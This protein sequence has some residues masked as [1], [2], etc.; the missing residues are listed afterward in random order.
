VGDERLAAPGSARDLEIDRRQIDFARTLHGSK[1]DRKILNRESGG[2]ENRD[3]GVRLTA[4]CFASEH[5]A[6]LCDFFACDRSCV[7]RVRKVAIVGR[8]LRVV[9]K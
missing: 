4:E 1:R 6:K 9:D 3:V 7:D 2:V 5:I 8:L